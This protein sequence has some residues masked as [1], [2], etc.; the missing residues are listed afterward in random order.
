MTR[1]TVSIKRSLGNAQD[2]DFTFL[3]NCIPIADARVLT[4]LCWFVDYGIACARPDA[5]LHCTSATMASDDPS[6]NAAVAVASVA[7]RLFGTNIASDAV[8]GESWNV[9]PIRR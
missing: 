9:R 8:I 1:Q 2:L 5:Y 6:T 3:M 4:L 7:A